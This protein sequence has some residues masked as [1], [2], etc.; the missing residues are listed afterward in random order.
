[1]PIHD[2]KFTSYSVVAYRTNGGTTTLMRAF[3]IKERPH[4]AFIYAI[5]IFHLLN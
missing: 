4:I 1:M 3:L 2:V 5:E